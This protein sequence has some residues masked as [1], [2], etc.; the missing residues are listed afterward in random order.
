VWRRN[1]LPLNL[2]F[3][4]QL[5][6]QIGLALVLVITVAGCQPITASGDP[7]ATMPTFVSRPTL[8]PVLPTWTALPT[9]VVLTPTGTVASEKKETGYPSDTRTGIAHLDAIVDAVL[10]NDPD[11]VRDLIH[12]TPVGCTTAEG[13]GGPPKCRSGEAQGTPVEVVPVLGPEGFALRRDDP[14]VGISAGDYR[15]MAAVSNVKESMRSE[16]WWLPAK[17]ALV[18]GSEDSPSAVILLADEAGIVRIIHVESLDRV[19]QLVSGDF[20]LPPNG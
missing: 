13:L 17:Y 4:I 3:Q 12:Y 9:T 10:A 20:I 16:D 15:L 5:F 14:S 19:W 7:S 6:I 11:R 2:T 18:F 8:T 1:N